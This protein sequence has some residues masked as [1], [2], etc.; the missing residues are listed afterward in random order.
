MRY[1]TPTPPVHLLQL[2]PRGYEYAQKPIP[3]LRKILHVTE[4]RQNLYITPDRWKQKPTGLINL[5]YPTWIAKAIKSIMCEGP[6]SKQRIYTAC[7][8]EPYSRPANTGLVGVS[9]KD[10][11]GAF[12]KYP[13]MHRCCTA[14][15]VPSPAPFR[16]STTPGN[17][18]RSH[19]YPISQN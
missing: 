9:D 7:Q 12:S 6:D 18:F 19:H 15:S 5:C 17:H 3:A 8:D 10:G 1:L 14:Q 2:Q 13:P 4:W 11:S 16:L